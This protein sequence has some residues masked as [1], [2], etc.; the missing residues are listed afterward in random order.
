M[1]EIFKEKEADAAILVDATNAFNSI[2]REAMLHN[3][4]VK[5]P[6]VNIYVQNC[7]G[8]P[9]KLFIVDWKKNGEKM[10]FIF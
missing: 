4:A 6:E 8:K 1:K 2:D 7:H 10:H 9:S 3:I 5:Y